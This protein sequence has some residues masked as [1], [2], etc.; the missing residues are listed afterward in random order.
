M[1]QR[2]LRDLFHEQLRDMYNAEGQLVKALPK[3]AKAATNPELRQGFQEHLE[4]TKNHQER[5]GDVFEVLGEKARGKTCEAMEG[6]VEEA[7][8]W[9][10]QDADPDDP[11]VTV[12]AGAIWD[13]IVD[14]LDRHGLVMP[15][16]MRKSQQSTA[17]PTVRMSAST[18]LRKSRS[19]DRDWMN[20]ARAAT[21]NG[22]SSR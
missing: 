22:Y 17:K 18:T 13:D 7:K 2:T 8:D 14:A 1:K 21:K 11:S 20:S 5:L 3:M 10:D 19:L 15:G 16:T 4:Q 6:L 12:G 9:L